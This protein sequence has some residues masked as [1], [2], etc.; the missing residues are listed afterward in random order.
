M[1]G[2]CAIVVDHKKGLNRSYAKGYARIPDS[3]PVSLNNRF[4]IGSVTKTMVATAVLQLIDEVKFTL[5]DKL[6]IFF[7]QYPKADSVTITMLLNMQSGIFNYTSDSL[8]SYYVFGGDP[9][10]VWTLL[11]LVNLSDN[12]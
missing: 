4:R 8:F 6:S 11:K 10:K 2:I 12:S 1:P 5:T 3:Q 7:L 9:N